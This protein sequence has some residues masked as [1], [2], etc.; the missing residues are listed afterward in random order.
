M[1]GRPFTVCI[2]FFGD[3]PELAYRNLESVWRSL[4]SGED[5][6]HDFRIGLNQIS[7]RTR[8]IVDWF[9]NNAVQHFGTPVTTWEC[10]QNACKY[11]MMRRML[12]ESPDRPATFTVWFDD[13]SYLS[14]PINWWS[15][16]Y[17][18]TIDADMLGKLYLQQTRGDQQL[19]VAKQSW[20]NPQ[21][22]PP[23]KFRGRP[24]F[25]FCTGGWWTIRSSVLFDHDWPTRELRHRG[26]DALL[27]ELCRHQALRM[28]NF[29]DGVRINADKN[30]R[31]SKSPRRGE[32]EMQLGV[33]IAPE[34]S[35]AHHDFETIVTK[36]GA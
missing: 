23:A 5:H 22:G 21:A 1:E 31:H 2:L 24:A 11:P 19:W 32:D 9:V 8:K 30:G 25:R 20:F 35:F 26:G 12:L 34:V 17:A 36:V 7:D 27:G 15:K 14:E 13:D 33:K 4:P 6:I 3:H 28:V 18:A 29:E 10:K 16:L